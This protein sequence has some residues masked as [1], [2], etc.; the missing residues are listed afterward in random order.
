[1]Y[2]R[3]GRVKFHFGQWVAIANILL[4]TP[5]AAIGLALAVHALVALDPLDALSPAALLAGSLLHAF[6]AMHLIA[7]TAR[8]RVLA[9]RFQAAAIVL[10]AL[11][12]ANASELELSA[13]AWWFVPVAILGGLQWLLLGTG[14]AADAAPVFVRPT[15]IREALGVL[16][17]VMLLYVLS[18]GPAALVGNWRFNGGPIPAL[19]EPLA[20]LHHLT[21]LERPLDAYLAVWRAGD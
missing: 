15:P 20:W 7:G 14:P 12:L 17:G 13:L 18:S 21:L 16:L 10:L 3:R 6:A 1:M 19:Y 4:A 8:D 5:G 11:G 2:A 9:G